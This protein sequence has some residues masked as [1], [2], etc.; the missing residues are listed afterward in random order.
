MLD[1]DGTDH[2]FWAVTD[3]AAIAATQ[4]AL[5]DCEILIADGHHRYETALNYREE[6][7]EPTA[8]PSG[9]QPYDFMLM[10]LANLH[11]EGLSI[12]PTHRVVMGAR[13]LTP[14]LLHAFDGAGARPPRRRSSRRELGAIPPETIA[15]A[16]V[17]R[18]R[19]PGASVHAAPTARR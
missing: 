17:A 18:L 15:F 2:R 3:P 6:R 4:A 10:Y 19:P 11:G 9:D 12:F 1:G 14:D 8:I 7:R 16:C 13:E 5:A